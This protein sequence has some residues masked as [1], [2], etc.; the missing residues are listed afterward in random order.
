MNQTEYYVTADDIGIRIDKFLFNHDIGLTR[1]A[2]QKLID[3]KSIS[4]NSAAVSKNYKLKENDLI[5]IDFTE[6]VKLDVLPQNIPIDIVYE[7]EI[8]DERIRH[9]YIF[10]M[11]NL[12]E[13]INRKC[14]NKSDIL[15][16]G[17]FNNIMSEAYGEEILNNA[18]YY[19][20]FVNLCQK[21]SYVIG[22]D[23]MQSETFLDDILK[24][25]FEGSEP[26]HIIMEKGTDEIIDY[27]NVQVMNIT[28]RKEADDGK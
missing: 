16:L 26:V 6:P 27:T 22:G 17:E 10:I 15:T 21:D 11:N 12:K 2:I 9:N 28:F 3:N 5:T 14:M 24:E 7:D 23:N 18:D 20:F 13:C 4:V 25:G 19:S 1:S 8:E